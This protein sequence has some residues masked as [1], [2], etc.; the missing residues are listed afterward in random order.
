MKDDRDRCDKPLG[1]GMS[2]AFALSFVSG[3]SFQ[4]P[5]D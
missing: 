5:V 4:C 1:E 2:Q 3:V